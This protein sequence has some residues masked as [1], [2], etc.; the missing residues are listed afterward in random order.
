MD[1]LVSLMVLLAIFAQVLGAFL[2]R[3]QPLVG[4]YC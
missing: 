2:V 4:G 3:D 1:T